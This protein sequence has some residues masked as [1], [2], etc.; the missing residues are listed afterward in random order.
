MIFCKELNQ[1]FDTKKEL[2]DALRERHKEIISVKKASI[3]K[4]V[5]KKSSVKSRPI[6]KSITNKQAFDDNNFC[7]IVVNTTKVLDSHLDLHINGIWDKTAR[8]RNRKNYLVDTHNM[9]V[10]TTIAR[11]EYVEIMI[12]EIPFELVGKDYGGNTQALIYKVAKNR[13]IDDKAR[14][15]LESGDSIEA[16]VR[17]QYVQIEFAMDSEQSEDELFKERFDRYIGDIANKEE[18]EEEFGDI[19][20]F[21]IVKEAKNVNESSLVLMGSNPATGSINTYE[22]NNEPRKSTHK[23]EQESSDG[24]SIDTQKR[25]NNFYLYLNG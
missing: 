11:K 5:D 15:W 20:Y 7:Y 23:T 12:E 16:S 3:Q 21:W 13:I 14:E 1:N 10:Q 18:F 6:S 22:D 24:P 19:S 2:F 9:S 25:S 17:M 4:S 8:E